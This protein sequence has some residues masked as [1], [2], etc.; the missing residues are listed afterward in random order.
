MIFNYTNWI[1]GSF[2][3]VR[4]YELLE[5]GKDWLNR[6]NVFYNSDERELWV[7]DND[8]KVAP[9]GFIR[10]YNMT[11]LLGIRYESNTR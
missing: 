8:K 4:E 1:D 2:G 10:L 9:E 11:Q 3:K 7:V 6:K 5:K